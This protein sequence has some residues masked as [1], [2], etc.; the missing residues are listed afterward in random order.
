[1]GR[2]SRAQAKSDP[3]VPLLADVE[4]EVDSLSR[5]NDRIRQ[6]EELNRRLERELEAKDTRHGE[7]MREISSILSS[8]SK[9]I[10]MACDRVVDRV[11]E[12]AESRKSGGLKGEGGEDNEDDEDVEGERGENDE[13]VSG[14]SRIRKRKGKQEQKNNKTFTKGLNVTA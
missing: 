4:P 1:M 14:G 6:L 8:L 3:I 7:R 10:S 9:R 13:K 12:A 11:V 2:R 5:A